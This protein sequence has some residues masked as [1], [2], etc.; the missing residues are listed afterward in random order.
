M[1]AVA[2]P[3]SSIAA[4]LRVSRQAFTATATWGLSLPTTWT[5]YRKAVSLTSIGYRELS[6][7]ESGATLCR[8]TAGDTFTLRIDRVSAEVPLRLRFTLTAIPY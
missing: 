2:V 3:G 6:T 8:S 1:D 7:D 4:P 5:Q